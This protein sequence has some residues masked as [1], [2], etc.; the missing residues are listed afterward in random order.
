MRRTGSTVLAG[1]LLV[2]LV[3]LAA[4]ANHR[5]QTYVSESGDVSLSTEREPGT[6]QRMTIATA[7]KYFDQYKLC[8]TAPDHSKVCKMF[9]M[10]E[11]AVD[12]YYSDPKWKG[13]FPNKGAGKYVVKWKNNGHGLGPALGF[14][15]HVNP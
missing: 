14:H 11:G 8:V 13:N 15:I 3:P 10:K 12:S 5:P 2:S 4:Q 6:P 1:V 7:A 9:K